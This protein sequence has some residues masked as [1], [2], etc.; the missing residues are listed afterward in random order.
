MK[1]DV[2]MLTLKSI[3][4][5]SIVVSSVGLPDS[6]REKKT[7]GDVINIYWDWRLNYL[8]QTTKSLIM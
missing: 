8:W 4:Q 2:A 6:E 7:F 1:K 3:A 5:T